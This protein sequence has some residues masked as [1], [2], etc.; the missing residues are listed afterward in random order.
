MLKCVWLCNNV[1]CCCFFASEGDS[2]KLKWI[3]HVIKYDVNTPNRKHTQKKKKRKKLMHQSLV[4]VGLST[5]VTR[6]HITLATHTSHWWHTHIV[7]TCECTFICT[8]FFFFFFMCSFYSSRRIVGISSAKLHIK[9]YYRNCFALCFAVFFFFSFSFVFGSRYVCWRIRK[10]F[11][12]QKYCVRTAHSLT[13]NCF[14]LFPHRLTHDKYFS[15]YC[16]NTKNWLSH[17][18]GLFFPFFVCFSDA[19]EHSIFD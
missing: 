3:V 9:N 13:I 18:L 14:V 7:I 19:C 17:H 8:A 16:V 1:K 6:T 15:T 2:H 10:L 12:S 4:I 11:C 5:I